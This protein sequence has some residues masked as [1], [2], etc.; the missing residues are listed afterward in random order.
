MD[1]VNAQRDK[2]LKKGG[3]FKKLEEEVSELGKNLAKVRTQVE[4][5]K[6][7]IKD[8]EGKIAASEKELEEVCWFSCL[9][10]HLLTARSFAPA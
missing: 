3:K 9:A 6:S 4:L 5:K 2:E 8:E 10:H 7:T 1:E